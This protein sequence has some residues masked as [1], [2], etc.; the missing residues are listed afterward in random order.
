MALR[1]HQD[2]FQF[3]QTDDETMHA[4]L[5]RYDN[6]SVITYERDPIWR[7]AV[8]NNVPSLLALHHQLTDFSDQYKVVMLNKNF[9][10]FHVIINLNLI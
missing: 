8:L 2:N 5:C 6:E 3:D 9:L 4:N 10:S 1:L 7:N